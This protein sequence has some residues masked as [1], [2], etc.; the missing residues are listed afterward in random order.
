MCSKTIGFISFKFFNMPSM[1]HFTT[2]FTMLCEKI[3]LAGKMQSSFGKVTTKRTI[4]QLREAPGGKQESII[5]GWLFDS[6]FDGHWPL[7]VPLEVGL[8]RISLIYMIYKYKHF[9]RLSSKLWYA[10]KFIYLYI[11]DVY[12]FWSVQR[13]T[14]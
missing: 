6:T 5:N 1:G 7:Q 9:L 14:K 8:H 2:Q 13:G 11:C 12:I 4:R 3:S 10:M